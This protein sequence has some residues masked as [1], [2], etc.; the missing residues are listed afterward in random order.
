[1]LLENLPQK[2]FLKDKNSVYIFCN[3]NMARDLKISIDEIAGKTDYDFFPTKL[4]VKYRADDVR[5]MNSGEIEEIEKSYIRKGQ[6]NYIHSVKTP[7]RDTD[8]NVI[9]LLGVSWDVTAH[10]KLEK[11]LEKQDKHYIQETV[12]HE[13][14]H[15]ITFDSIQQVKSNIRDLWESTDF[16]DTVFN[17]L[18]GYAIVAADF[19]GNILAYN[20]GARLIYGFAPEEVVGKKSIVTFFHED[21]IAEGKLDNLISTLIKNKQVSFEGEQVRKTGEKFPAQIL[22]TATESSSKGFIGL[23]AM[24]EDITLRKRAEEDLH[25]SEARFRQMIRENVDGVIIVGNDGSVRFANPAAAHLLDS[26]ISQL[27]GSQFGLPIVFDKTSDIDINISDAGIRTVAMCAVTMEWQNESVVLVTL[28]DVTEQKKNLEILR[29]LSLKDELTGLLNR[30]GFMTLAEYELKLC[31]RNKMN[32]VMVY[33]DLDR[34]K[35]INDNLGHEEGDRA[36]INTADILKRIFRDSDI[37]A[38]LGG[39]EFAVLLTGGT[40]KGT[41]IAIGRL[42]LNL[43]AHNA[44]PYSRYILSLSI[45]TARYDHEHACSLQD[46]LNQADVSMYLEKKA[47]QKSGIEK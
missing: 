10:N 44:R 23:V 7:I 13:S 28:R 21:F 12:T 8:G 39:D 15:V 41:E 5:I 3:Q 38:R 42:R 46:L 36:L 1:M 33:A 26:T 19:D 29:G 20:E 45:G 4:A 37:V 35:W 14:G 22:F 6:V 31:I 24:I 18:T 43:S 40:A 30:R 32:T 17:G 47:K 2:I 34:M 16:M 9:G 11:E 25:K 27:Q